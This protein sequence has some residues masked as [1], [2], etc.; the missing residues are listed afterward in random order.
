M[1]YIIYYRRRLGCSNLLELT[2]NVNNR[3]KIDNLAHVECNSECDH[4][5]QKVFII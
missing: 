2:N 1:I 4:T 5:I 3:N